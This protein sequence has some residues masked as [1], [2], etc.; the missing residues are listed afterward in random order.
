MDIKEKNVVYVCNNAYIWMTGISMLSLLSHNSGIHVYVVCPDIQ[1]NNRLLLEETARSYGGC[2]TILHVPDSFAMKKTLRQ[3]W[4]F[5][6]I[7]RLFA[8]KIFT[9]SYFTTLSARRHDGASADVWMILPS[10]YLIF[11]ICPNELDHGNALFAR[12]GGRLFPLP[13]AAKQRR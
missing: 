11:L 7:T 8:A 4:P 1:Q 3:R 9:Q 13:T 12:G 6:T 2:C 5:F 10:S